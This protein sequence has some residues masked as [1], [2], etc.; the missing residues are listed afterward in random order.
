MYELEIAWCI[1]RIKATNVIEVVIA[2]GKGEVIVVVEVEIERI[3][4][5]RPKIVI[6]NLWYIRRVTIWLPTDMFESISY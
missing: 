3:I 5:K 1:R 6:V 2:E 4:K